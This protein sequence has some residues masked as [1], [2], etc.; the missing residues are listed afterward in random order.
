MLQTVF[1]TALTILVG[2][3][4]LEYFLEDSSNDLVKLLTSVNV[5]EENARHWYWRVIGNN[6][7]FFLVIGF[8]CLFSLFFLKHIFQVLSY[9]FTRPAPIKVLLPVTTT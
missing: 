3:F 2:G 4:I 7:D 6:K 9:C 8:L 5:Q 1:V